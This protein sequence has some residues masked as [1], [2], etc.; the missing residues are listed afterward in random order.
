MNGP[1]RYRR[2]RALTAACV[3]AL[4]G[5]VLL[6]LLAA[7]CARRE[8]PSGGPPDLTPPTLVSSAP[9]SGS[10]GVA[11]SARLAL[12]FS[13]TMEPRSTQAAVQ[14]APPVPIRSFRWMRRTLVLGLDRPLDA[15]RVY[16]LI[17]GGSARDR[18]GNTMVSG[19]TIL[20]S[21]G[22]QFPAGRI[23][24]E[25]DAKGFEPAG[26]FLWT[27]DASRTHVPDSTG[28]DFDALGLVD[29]HGR[30]HV[31]GLPVP[32]HYRLWAFADLDLNRSFDPDRDVLAAID[33]VIDLA[34]DRPV[35]GP[36]HLR[37][38]NPRAPGTI[39]GTVTDS[40]ADSTGAVRVLAV[41]E[42][43][44]TL[45]GLVEP[46]KDGAFELSLKPGAW[47]VRVFLDENKD[48]EWDPRSEPASEPV[49][50]ELLPADVT[51]D[52]KLVL[53]R[54]GG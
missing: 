5:S 54:R 37:L 28:R 15:D 38:V 42:R 25:V 30:F 35:A 8:P 53:R 17:V 32:G 40:L 16:T 3:L 34:A 13:E 49:R 39:R 51:K 50:I 4:L 9:D 20:F 45:V 22:A 14:L 7:G 47:T 46:G 21:T 43:D 18:H 2:R 31:D 24:G 6:T 26:T 1:A 48:R 33:T 41:N 19:A 52:V 11:T 10:S 29:E 12:T 23:A 27:Y 36:I 44:T